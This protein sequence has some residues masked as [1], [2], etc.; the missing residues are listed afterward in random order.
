MKRAKWAVMILLAFGLGAPL[1]VSAEDQGTTGEVSTAEASA[2]VA[3][4]RRQ[5]ST[6]TFD[7]E[8]SKLDWISEAPA[9]KIVGTA[10]Q[11][12]GSVSWDLQNLEA[13]QGE[14]LIPVESMKSGNSLRDRHLRGR[15]WLQSR[16]NPN[17]IFRLRGLEDVERTEQDDQIRVEAVAVGT[18]EVNG[19]EAET[20]ARISLAILPGTKRVR[21]QP[22]FQVRL[23]EHNV[24]GR[25][26]SI[27]NEVGESIDISGVLYG[28]WE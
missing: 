16:D 1:S 9:E 28:S 23:G 13:T 27:G 6:L 10:E 21:I 25:R 3:A 20:R 14:I 7:R 2:P 24:R 11:V 22:E 19:E 8:R 12:S 5:A 26:G 15:D 4:E 17:I 18:I